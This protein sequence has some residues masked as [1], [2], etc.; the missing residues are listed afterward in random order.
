[1]SVAEGVLSFYSLPTLSPLTGPAFTPL[2]GVSTFALDEAVLATGGYTQ[3]HLVIIK[4]KTL[5]LLNVTPQGVTLVRVSHHR[6]PFRHT[7]DR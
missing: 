3:I 5:Q 7:S 6:R 2:R 1:M 4:R